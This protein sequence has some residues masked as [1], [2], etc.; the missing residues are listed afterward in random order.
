MHSPYLMIC[1]R[2]LSTMCSC[3]YPFFIYQGATTENANKWCGSWIWQSHLPPNFSSSGIF[4]SNYL[5]SISVRA[6]SIEATETSTKNTR[7]YLTYLLHF[8]D[9]SPSGISTPTSTTRGGCRT[10][11]GG[12]KFTT[13]GTT[14]SYI[15]VTSFAF[16][17]TILWPLDHNSG[18]L[19]GSSSTGDR[20]RFPWSPIAPPTIHL[21]EITSQFKFSQD[22][23]K[24]YLAVVA[25]VEACS[26]QHS[27]EELQRCLK[28]GVQATSSAPTIV[29]KCHGLSLLRLPDQFWWS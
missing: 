8:K 28:L 16:P 15:C 27:E 20:A 24:L 12:W 14:A 3:E 11:S 6:Q 1:S 5:G 17:S 21:K 23:C 29:T 22:L 9:H 25:K 4:T 19:L 10:N 13:L 26:I 7:I 2:W 18:T